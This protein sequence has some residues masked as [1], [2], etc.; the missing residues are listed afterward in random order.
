MAASSRPSAC[1][2]R[3]SRSCSSV[4][5][6]SDVSV[7]DTNDDSSR[8]GAPASSAWKAWRRARSGPR[9]MIPR[10]ALCPSVAET[11]AWCPSRSRAAMA[12]STRL[13]APG[14]AAAPGLSI[15][16]DWRSIE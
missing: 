4:L 16:L 2:E 14:S 6:Y 10:S 3:R 8:S 11:R 15:A 1:E 12:S 5:V 13:A 9:A 7:S